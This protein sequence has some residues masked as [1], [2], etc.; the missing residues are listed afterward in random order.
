MLEKKVAVRVGF[1]PTVP[2][3]V[4]RF[5][6]PPDSTALAPHRGGRELDLFYQAPGGPVQL[7]YTGASPTLAPASRDFMRSSALGPA[8]SRQALASRGEMPATPNATP[9]FFSGPSSHPV[10]SGATAPAMVERV[11]RKPMVRPVKWGGG[12]CWE[13]AQ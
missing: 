5:S 6:R 10:A 2:V 3:K 8:R 9:K 1:E 13:M 4:Q 11:F 12:A 7:L